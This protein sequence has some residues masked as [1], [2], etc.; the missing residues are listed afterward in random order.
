MDSHFTTEKY[1]IWKGTKGLAVKA[2][3]ALKKHRKGHLVLGPIGGFYH[4][5]LAAD[6]VG[7]EEFLNKYQKLH[8]EKYGWS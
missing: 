5:V 8:F 4:F 7:H 2:A 6:T 3:K 1:F